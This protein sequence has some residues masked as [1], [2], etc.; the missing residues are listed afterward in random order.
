MK[1]I[2]RY[3]MFALLYFAQGSIMSF[4]TA[5]NALYLQTFELNMSQIGLIGT[6]AMIPFVIKIFLGMLSDKVNFLGLGYRKPYIVIGLFIQ[7]ACLFVVPFINPKSNFGLYAVLAFILMTG[8]ALYDTC[9]DGL[10]LDSTPKEEEG[11][12]QGFMVGGRAIGMVLVSA[13]IGVLVEHYPW[14]YAFYFLAVITLL[15]L[16]FVIF[17]KE[18]ERSAQSKF[19]WQAFKS[20]AKPNVV[21]LGIL[22]A[23]YSL[24]IYGANQLVNP[25]LSEKFS[26]SLETAGFVT[27]VLGLELSWV[28]WPVENSQTR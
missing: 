18:T 12:I 23:L 26:I 13:V 15:P 11:I 21:S 17:M 3:L 24:V 6:I 2:R 19:E 16:P 1:E 20:F 5:L 28:V 22:G 7:A 14:K 25:Y 10:A 9:T 4:F 8:M 27:T